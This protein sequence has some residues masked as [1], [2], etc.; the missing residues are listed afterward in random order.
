[1]RPPRVKPESLSVLVQIF[2]NTVHAEEQMLKAYR[3]ILH[4][5][6]LM[7][8]RHEPGSPLARECPLPQA[9]RRRGIGDQGGDTGSPSGPVTEPLIGDD[10]ESEFRDAG[11]PSALPLASARRRVGRPA[12]TEPSRHARYR[13]RHPDYRAREALRK[14][15]SPETTA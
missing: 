7:G 12:S 10:L 9:E 4:G 2:Q 1:M 6:C 14:S 5:T 11:K 3:T 15:R 13:R 8:G